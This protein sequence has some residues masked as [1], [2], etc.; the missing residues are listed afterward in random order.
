M[1]RWNLVLMVLSIYN[2]FIISFEISFGL[3]DSFLNAKQFIENAVDFLFFFD[4]ALIFFTSFINKY[5][6]EVTNAYE[7]YLNYTRSWRFVFDSLSLLGLSF[8]RDVH[9]FFK[10]FQLFKA[11]RVARIGKMIHR[12]SLPIEMKSV[13]II[14]KLVLYLFLYNHWSACLWN[15]TISYKENE[16]AASD[17][18]NDPE[19]LMTSNDSLG[20]SQFNDRWNSRSSLWVSPT[21]F[22]NPADSI[23][24][25]NPKMGMRYLTMLYYSIIG[26]G[27]GELGPKNIIEF[28]YCVGFMIISAFTFNHVFG[29]ISGLFNS[30]AADSVTFQKELDSMNMILAHIRLS[31]GAK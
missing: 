24:L 6:V 28:V 11:T 4:N 25:Q 30:L 8:F 3:P 7:I 29:Q 15:I 26:L 22:V 23:L 16:E 2:A 17:R 21:D 5:G 13:L 18:E 27:I 9:P 20:W 1:M 10:Y 14:G 31:D 12:S 19:M